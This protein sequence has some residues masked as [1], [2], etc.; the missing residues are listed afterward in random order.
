MQTN[1]KT[2]KV[3]AV[4]A[5]INDKGGCG[6]STSTFHIAGELARRG[7]KVLVV[8]ADKQRNTSYF[9]LSEEESEYD[10]N[11]SDT[12]LEL[13]L[14]KK[15]FE[16]VVKKNYIKEGNAKPKYMGIDVIPASVELEDQE[17]YAPILKNKNFTGIFT[18]L[19]YDYVLIDCPPSNRMIEKIVLEQLAT[20]VLIPMSNDISSVLGMGDL[21]DKIDKAREQNPELK[22]IGA[23]YSMFL[24][25]TRKSKMYFKAMENKFPKLFIPEYIPFCSDVKESLEDE[26]RPLAFYRKSKA[27]GN[28][29]NLISE[30]LNR[31]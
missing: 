28:Y 10:L 8:D 14:E 5:V 1:D 22:L 25:R 4:I 3:R 17:T 15:T 27:R 11:S 30:I 16:E 18:E 9:L 7:R 23:F 19:D 29:E 21:I 12:L 13:F 24:P 20:H 2:R 31:L 6:K 26:G